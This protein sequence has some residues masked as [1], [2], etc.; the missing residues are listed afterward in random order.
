MV[1]RQSTEEEIDLTRQCTVEYVSYVINICG[2]YITYQCLNFS[3]HHILLIISLA[4]TFP[5]AY[6]TNIKLLPQ[7]F[8]ESTWLSGGNN[9]LSLQKTV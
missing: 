9:I 5:S 7:N 1:N 8:I 3:I 2:L 6:T 4:K